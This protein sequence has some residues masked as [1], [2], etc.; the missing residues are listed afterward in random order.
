MA[1]IRVLAESDRKAPLDELRTV[2]GPL[3]EI[4]TE[5]GD[6]QEWAQLVLRHKDGPEIALIERNVVLPG[7][8]G[9]QVIGEL[10]EEMENARPRRATAWLEHFFS[11]VKVVYAMQVLSGAEGNDGWS[12]V[13]RVQAYIW[14][15]SGGILQADDEGFTNR[16]GQHILW[17]FNGAQTGELEAAVMNDEGQ[18][19]AFS[20]D[21][22]DVA[23]VDAFQRGEAL[24][25]P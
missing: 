3:F 9:E 7:E 5:H 10:R 12:A 20:L 22:L 23:Q 17:Q 14:K 13:L 4:I 18:W 24:T 16:E 21:M 8:P 19:V 6:E 1:H 11:H 15:K 2:L 25:K